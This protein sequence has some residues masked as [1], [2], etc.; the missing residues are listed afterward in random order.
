MHKIDHSFKPFTEK[1]VEDAIRRSSNSTAMGPD[2]LTALHLKHLGPSGIGFLTQLF[3]LSVSNAD[4][5][6]IW[7]RASI[8]PILK[9]NK[10]PSLSTSYR[11]I[12]LLS[13]S[14]KILERLLLPFLNAS[15]PS[16]SSQH[17]F[18]AAHS[19]TTALLPISTRVA[20]GFNE[21]KPPTRTATVAIDISK[22]FDSVDHTLLIEQIMETQLESNIVRWIAA[23]LRG[24]TASCLFR[25]TKS[26]LRIIRSGVPQGSVISPILFNFFVSDLPHHASSTESYADDIY[27]S[28]SS[29]DLPTITTALNEDM[30]HISQWA[31]DKHLS[32]A[33]EKSTIT[34]FTPDPAQAKFHPQVLL[35]GVIIPLDKRPKYLGVIHTTQHVST[36]HIEAAGVKAL[37]ELNVL[38][39]LTGTSWGHQKKTL[40]NT[41]K[42]IIR[43]IFTSG[44]PI[45]FPN[46]SATA[47]AKLQTVQNAALRI[48]TGCHKKT[49]IDHLHQETKVLPVKQHLQM[50]CEQFLAKTLTRDHPSHEVV[51]QPQ[52][53]RKK[54]ATL[55][56]SCIEPIKH[57]LQD[58]IVLGI[59]YKRVIS[60]I[61]TDTVSS[62]IGSLSPNKVLGSRPPKVSNT[63]ELLPRAYQCLNHQLRSKYCIHLKS[64][65]HSIGKCDSPTCPECG[66][67][68][69][70]TNHLFDCPS[71]PTDLVVLD[72][73][74]RPC[75]VAVFFSTLPSFAH[76]PPLPTHPLRPPPEPPPTGVISSD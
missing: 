7:K 28:E 44:A 47:I 6:V 73:W 68:P 11:P 71:F 70:T 34:L 38:R 8:I 50:L 61:H 12:S 45:W 40:L 41:Y 5:P 16:S 58:G 24:R 75:V 18:K 10:P 25:S 4:L 74:H 17:G 1:D 63:E 49:S 14:I 31:E 55:Y 56:S 62:V 30:Q 9:P 22:A 37:R 27:V 52:G 29:S 21:E 36:P 39:A 67:V 65:L 48:A 59:N 3:N 72:L 64:Y 35:D 54:K 19:C 60:A 76:L 23:Y 66:L 15:L 20:N 13:P 69:H 33:P 53:P 51:M 57:H 32:I 2:G 26:P 43:P 42:M 46:A